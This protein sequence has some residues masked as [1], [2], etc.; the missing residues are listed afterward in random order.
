[1][2]RDIDELLFAAPLLGNDLMLRQLILDALRISILTINLV[3]CDNQRDA[4][5]FCM[6]NCLYRLRH[7]AVISSDNKNDDIRRLCP[8]GAHG[9]KGSVTR[10]IQ[11][12]DRTLVGCYGISADMLR[13]PACLTRSNLTVPDVVKQRGLAVIDMAHNRHYRCARN[14]LAAILLLVRKQL[15]VH[16]RRLSRLGDVSQFLNHKRRCILIDHL[17]DRHHGAHI[18]QDLDDFVTFYC[19]AF[20][21]VGDRNTLRNLNFV[22]NRRCRALESM[23]GIAT[24]RYRAP[25]DRR[26]TLA[27][28]TLVAGNMQFLA[29]VACLGALR[30]RLRLFL[31]A[32][33]ASIGLGLFQARFFF[34]RVSNGFLSCPA[35]LFF[36]ILASLLFLLLSFLFSPNRRF[37]LRLGTLLLASLSLDALFLGTALCIQRFLFFQRLLLEHIPLDVSA[38]AAHLNIDGTRAPLCTRQSQLRLR[39]SLERNTS[40]RGSCC[41]GI[42]LSV[43]TAQVCQQFELRFIAD[44]CIRTTDLDARFIELRQQ[45]L[46]RHLQYFS[47]LSNCHFSHTLTPHSRRLRLLFFLEP[48]CT[49]FHN[50]RRR[51]FFF[52]FTDLE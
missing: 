49:R 33:R 5:S 25:A 43:A 10:C 48:V 7:H 34:S 24:D 11:E 29:A 19:Q 42:V 36:S 14:L 41:R 31:G 28:P 15:L 12:R 21:E 23:L 4:G 46:N 16:L 6:L 30:F 50:K 37:L 40:R 20:G 3:N 1:M 22:N 47:K 39:L 18:E 52:Q 8:S 27:A 35:C 38:L 13:N 17:V 44:L 2:C 45:L 32:T 9:G 51:F 26:L